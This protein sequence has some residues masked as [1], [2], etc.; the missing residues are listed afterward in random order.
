MGRAERA[1]YLGLI[2]SGVWT[3]G[4]V[5]RLHELRT[6]RDVPTAQIPEQFRTKP[7]VQPES[8]E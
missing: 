5:A 4:A 1:E 7:A 2:R 6:W 8:Q 3:V